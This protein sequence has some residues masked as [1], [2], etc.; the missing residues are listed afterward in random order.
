VTE[1]IRRNFLILLFMAAIMA[2]PF[3]GNAGD[4]NASASVKQETKV[5]H[6]SSTNSNGGSSRMKTIIITL[7]ILLS[8]IS[9]TFIIERGLALR[10]SKVIP[11]GLREAQQQLQDIDD[12]PTL[13][14]YCEHYDSTYGR[15]LA[16]AINNRHL[17]RQ[18]NSESLQT[19]A[20]HEIAKLERGLVVLEITTG[21]A[22][23]LGLVG[24]I[25]G[26]ITLFKAM[27][28]AGADQSQFA[29]GIS[30]ALQATLLGLT[31]AIPSLTAWS[32]YSKRIETFAVEIESHCDEF[33]R[34]HYGRKH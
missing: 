5:D 27:G 17:S 15:L 9:L 13:K 20:R 7:L 19:R 26:L 16:Y 32:L 10:S 1:L 6:D 21:I 11:P 4:A 30:I 2:A 24:T 3:R 29:D 14:T 33:L 34:K 25:F 18:E 12:L 28:V 22:P 23:L 31:I 8:V